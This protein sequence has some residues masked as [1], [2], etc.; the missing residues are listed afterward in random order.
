MTVLQQQMRHADVRTTLAIYSHAIPETQ[1]DAMEKLAEL[2]IGT[3]V[4]IGTAKE[5]QA[6]SK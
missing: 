5:T 4:P 3:F 1:R 2:S 6:V